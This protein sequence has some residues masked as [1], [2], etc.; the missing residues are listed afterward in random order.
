MPKNLKDENAPRRPLTP[1]FAWMKDNRARLKSENP[2]VN[3]KELTKLLGENWRKSPDESKKPYIDTATELMGKW[4]VLMTA[5]KK[6]ENYTD[7]QRR[8][9][10]FN[11]TKGKKGKKPKRPKDPNAPKRPST[12]FF[13][14]VAAKRAEV[15]ASLPPAQQK[16]VTVVTKRCGQLWNDVANAGEKAE[17][18]AKAKKLK[19]DYNALMEEYKKTDKFQEY[20]E[21]LKEWKAEQNAAP[22]RQKK[23]RAVVH[24]RLDSSDSDSTDDSS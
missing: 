13:L 3:N 16:K 2:T 17:F 18:Q 20:Q 21:Y 6:T 23:T 19:E 7:F 22:P 5:Y 9:K 4:K 15:K 1:Y 12:G 14:F 11:A 24:R 8:K 10:E